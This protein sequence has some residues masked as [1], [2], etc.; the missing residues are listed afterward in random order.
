VNRKE[1]QRAAE[2]ATVALT[3]HYPATP[4]INYSYGKG[5]GNGTW[6]AYVVIEADDALSLA[7][8]LDGDPR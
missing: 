5:D 7:K 6:R 8:F 4:Q 3:E 1:A 2:V